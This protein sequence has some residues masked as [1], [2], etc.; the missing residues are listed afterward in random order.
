[1]TEPDREAGTGAGP[2]IGIDVGGTNLRAAVVDAAGA[3][4]EVVSAVTPAEPDAL[5]GALVEVIGELAGRHEVSA[6][7]L[8]VA[9]FVSRDRQV[10]RFAPHLPWRDAAVPARI[11]DRVGLPV[12]LEHDAN[13]AAWGEACFGPAGAGENVAV[14]AIGT[15]IGAA[16]LVDGALYRGSNGVAPEL[17]HLPVVPGGRPCA[18]GKSGCFERYCSGTALAATAAELLAAHP[19]RPSMLARADVGVTGAAVAD[20]A[21]AGD[22]VA[23]EAMADFAHWLGVGLSIVADVFDP[24]LIVVA[25][26]V[27]SSAP[28][29]LDDARRAYAGLVT[30]AGHRRLARIRRSEL[31]VAAAMIGAAELARREAAAAEAARNAGGPAVDP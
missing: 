11:A 29:F 3:A 16:L 17:G 31:G 22:A 20:A 5:D 6:V 30:G 2:A 15:G 13:S 10:V 14:V 1:M 21:A 18:C 12:V 7:G 4:V 23:L 26:G 24:D 28:L 25:G 8:A 19:G 27:A 9:G